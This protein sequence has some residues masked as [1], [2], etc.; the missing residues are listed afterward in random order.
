M[1]LLKSIQCQITVLEHG[2]SRTTKTLG[3]CETWVGYLP[4]YQNTHC[5]IPKT[6]FLIL[7]AA[8]MQTS[9]S[10]KKPSFIYLL[11]FYYFQKETPDVYMRRI[12]FL[13]TKFI[14]I[15]VSLVTLDIHPVSQRVSFT[16]KCLSETY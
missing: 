13:F 2:T 14:L 15:N 12:Y 8:G 7:N 9:Q 11:N 3:S 4:T 16:R 6:L 10:S 5:D 1:S